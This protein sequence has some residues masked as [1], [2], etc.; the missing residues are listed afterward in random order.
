MLANNVTV[1]QAIEV[2]ID[3]GLICDVVKGSI[4]QLKGHD[5]RQRVDIAK[6]I[7]LKDLGRNVQD[8]KRNMRRWNWR[9]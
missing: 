2:H 7:M 1:S 6:N 4:H 3:D 8:G 5:I 9:R